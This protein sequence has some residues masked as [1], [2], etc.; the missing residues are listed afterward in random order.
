MKR[1]IIVKRDR[2]TWGVYDTVR[3]SWPEKVTDFG[4]VAQHHAT[5]AAAEVEA[6][7]LDEFYRKTT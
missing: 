2:D 4:Q 3:A 7:R 6:V 5:E 1:R